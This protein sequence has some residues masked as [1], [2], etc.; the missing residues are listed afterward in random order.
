MD[1]EVRLHQAAQRLIPPLANSGYPPLV[2][3]YHRRA[4]FVMNPDNTPVVPLQADPDLLDAARWLGARVDFLVIPANGPHI[5]HA[6]IEQAAGRPILSLI[7]ATL[8]E[9]RRRGAQKVGILGFGDPRVAIYTYP[10]REMNL[11]FETIG[12]ELQGPL[13]AAIVGVMEGRENADAVQAARDAVAALRAA[14]TDAIIL[15]CT[16]IPLLLRDDLHQPDLINPA[17]LLAEAAV[18]HALA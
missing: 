6:Q 7:H 1:F 16:E 9:V 18:R 11:A 8:G 3:Y 17:H 10:L 4:P 12:G 5:V 13:N 2:V 15:G 14:G